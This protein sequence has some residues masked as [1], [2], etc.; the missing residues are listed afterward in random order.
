MQWINIRKK[1]TYIMKMFKVLA[2]END[3]TTFDY[4]IILWSGS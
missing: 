1:K 3:F 4:L 2:Q